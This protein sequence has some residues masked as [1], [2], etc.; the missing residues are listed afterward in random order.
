MSSLSQLIRLHLKILMFLGVN[1]MAVAAHEFGHALGLSHSSVPGSL[2][3]P[4]YQSLKDGDKLP[5]DD[6]L[7]IQRLYGTLFHY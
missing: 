5:Y 6:T 3:F 1:L 2:M 4:Y 7:G